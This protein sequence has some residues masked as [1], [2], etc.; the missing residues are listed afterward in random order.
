MGISK[1]IKRIESILNNYINLYNADDTIVYQNIEY[2]YKLSNI[3]YK[4]LSSLN[5]RDT[6][7]TDYDNITRSN[8]FNNLDLIKSFYSQNNINFNIDSLINNG[9][10][11]FE[12]YDYSSDNEDTKLEKI[13]H[14]LVGENSIYNHHNVISTC[15]NN[16]IT[17]SAILVHELSHYRDRQM[18]KEGQ[19]ASLFTEGIAMSE[20]MIY[21]DYLTSL[22]YENDAQILKKIDYSNY[23]G[24]AYRAQTLFKFFN[25]Y[26]KLG[27]ISESCYLMLYKDT[28]NYREELAHF[29]YIVNNSDHD[30]YKTG[31][32]IFGYGI[33]TYMYYKYK[34]D[35]NFLNK[36]ELLHTKIN[37]EDL[38]SCLKTIG[39][40]EL[41]SKELNIMNKDMLRM[42]EELSSYNQKRINAPKR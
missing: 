37:T 39:L 20:E 6:I 38:D 27:S 41:G 2:L 29:M 31:G 12:Y 35:N 19:V 36:I 3:I 18:K 22:G 33:S 4:S 13:N 23:K 15:N 7:N 14:F 9:S 25:L 21:L 8:L 17:D 40:N 16:L 10:I 28:S 42:N 32:Y 5:I 26:Q 24:D 30:I 11:D 1:E 34:E